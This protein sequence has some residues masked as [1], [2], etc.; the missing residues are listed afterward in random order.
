MRRNNI[1]ES[2]ELVTEMLSVSNDIIDIVNTICQDL[3]KTY[4]DFTGK[5][6]EKGFN[7][8][9]G[10]IPY[11]LWSQQITIKFYIYDF[12]TED[13]FNKW[14]DKNREE[15]NFDHVNGVLN[16]TVI[17]L[18][19]RV[20]KP[21]CEA[22]MYHELEHVYQLYINRENKPGYKR[23]TDDAYAFANYQIWTAPTE[24]ER[25]IG[26][27]MYYSNPREQDAF[28]HE[29]YAQSKNSLSDFICH[30]TD[31]DKMFRRYGEY[32]KWFDNSFDR[33]DFKKLLEP[34][35]QYGYNPKN[36]KVYIDNGFNRFK[37]KINHVRAL[38][39]NTTEDPNAHKKIGQ[40]DTGETRDEVVREI[41]ERV[42]NALIELNERAKKD[43]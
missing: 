37:N 31:T 16:L 21:K 15:N 29:Y 32:T 34:Y 30:T 2:V 36:M 7:V 43:T 22:T 9:I 33:P 23:I 28:T 25:K 40:T 41:T 11:Q 27:L 12:W 26:I 3:E 10:T 39:A 42:M 5:N 19:G 20:Y 18:Y 13:A 6:I 17:M 8:R 1:T 4:I 38:V 14:V 35:R 24:D